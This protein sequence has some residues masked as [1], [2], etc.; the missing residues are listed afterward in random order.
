MLNYLSAELY[1]LRRH[2]GLYFIL[3]LVVLGMLCLYL[4]L[5]LLGFGDWSLEVLPL[6]LFV[7]FMVVPGLAVA[8]FDDQFGRGTL[9]NEVVFGVPR[10]R[11][12]LGKLLAGMLAGGVCSALVLGLYVLLAYL[13]GARI[14]GVSPGAWAA[15]V[16]GY[17]LPMWLAQYAMTFCLLVALKSSAAGVAL[18]YG[19]TFFG[20]ILSTLDERFYP[21]MW[22]FQRFFFTAPL[23]ETTWG[24]ELSLSQPWLLG[25][26][27]MLG[28]SAVGLWRL[29]RQELR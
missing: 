23:R 9:K 25:V 1:K 17:C 16:W 2:K 22:F 26:G 7:G 3:A 20:G 5:I 8:A 19:C 18:A 12:Y 4:P 28:T 24:K 29:Y 10:Y 11:A 27:W 13:G 15:W 6:A 14:E 21:N